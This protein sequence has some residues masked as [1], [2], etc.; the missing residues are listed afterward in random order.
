MKSPTARPTKI[1]PRHGDTPGTG[2]RQDA[3]KSRA[4]LSAVGSLE[5]CVECGKWG[6]QVAHRNEGKGMGYK[7]ADWLTAAL[8]P[9]C[10]DAIDNGKG[11]SLEERRAAM[12]RAIVLTLSKLV[13]R[14]LVRAV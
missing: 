9:A 5:Q 7:A 13:E 2:K 11:M 10:H 4:W 12:D 1:V 6:V 3:S 8:C 14:G